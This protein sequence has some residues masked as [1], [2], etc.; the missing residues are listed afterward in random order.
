MAIC[1]NQLVSHRP[2]RSHERFRRRTAEVDIAS[3]PGSRGRLVGPGGGHLARGASLLG[4]AS[5]LP[6]ADQ[7]G[8]VRLELHLQRNLAGVCTGQL[9]AGRGLV[10]V[11]HVVQADH[12]ERSG[13]HLLHLRARYPSGKGP[14][15]TV[16]PNFPELNGVGVGGSFASYTP[17]ATVSSET[18]ASAPA[19][20]DTTATWKQRTIVVTF[21]RIGSVGGTICAGMNLEHWSLGSTPDQ[22]SQAQVLAKTITSPSC[23]DTPNSTEAYKFTDSD[24]NQTASLYTADISTN[25]NNAIWT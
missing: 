8:R 15:F 13:K 3:S 10:R 21:K 5:S 20:F 18:S 14:A 7:R 24:T 4:L 11:Q 1:L 12:V 23:T 9:R 2:W 19:G 17:S 22:G 16:D 6:A 25:S